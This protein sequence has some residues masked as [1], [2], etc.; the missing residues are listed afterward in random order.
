M[1]LKSLKIPVIHEPF[2]PDDYTE[3]GVE[4]GA[5][6]TEK[7]IKDKDMSLIFSSTKALNLKECFEWMEGHKKEFMPTTIIV[8]TDDG[9]EIIS[10]KKNL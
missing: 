4:K 5:K 7:D 3:H 1:K 2:I 6:V 10:Y 8:D 9:D